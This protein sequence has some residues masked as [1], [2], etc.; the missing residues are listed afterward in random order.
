MWFDFT[1]CYRMSDPIRLEPC[2]V[3]HNVLF[4]PLKK[5]NAE[6][7]IK[8]EYDGRGYTIS[9]SSGADGVYVWTYVSY[10]EGTRIDR[11]P[12]DTNKHTL[13]M[14]PAHDH[15]PGF[16]EAVHGQSM[17][18]FQD[19]FVL[20]CGYGSSLALHP[21]NPSDEPIVIGDRDI[22]NR[23]GNPWTLVHR[24]ERKHH[25]GAIGSVRFTNIT[26]LASNPYH[27]HLFI[28]DAHRIRM[29]HY[30]NDR[31]LLICCF[32]IT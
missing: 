31:C 11:Y 14:K 29:L 20:S 25:D 15:G 23:M 13:V 30:G 32:D 10:Y 8:E 1:L 5:L 12:P 19:F 9:M 4:P 24:A 16:C 6:L 3:Y 26:V 7:K 18:C 17:A 27:D 22:Y 21:I 2:H 28:G